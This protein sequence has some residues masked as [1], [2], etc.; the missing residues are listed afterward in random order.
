MTTTLILS[1]LLGA[2]TSYPL[3]KRWTGAEAERLKVIEDGWRTLL[4]PLM[5]VLLTLSFFLY[6][7][8][9]AMLIVIS[10]VVAAW[11][12]KLGVLILIGIFLVWSG[13]WTVPIFLL[14]VLALLS[15]FLVLLLF[16]PVIRAAI[17]AVFEELKELPEKVARKSL[18]LLH[19]VIF[20]SLWII[21]SEAVLVSANGGS[22]LSDSPDLCAW[23]GGGRAVPALLHAFGESDS[24]VSENAARHLSTM[25][26]T[27]VQSLL[28]KL[29][30]HPHEGVRRQAK[31]ILLIQGR[32]K[33]LFDAGKITMPELIG[34]LSH[35][36]WEVRSSV[37]KEL[38]RIGRPAL[39]DLLARLRARTVGLREDWLVIDTLKQIVTLEDVLR[40]LEVATAHE[41]D[42]PP[43]LTDLLSS[44]SPSAIPALIDGFK[45]P[46]PQVRNL[47]RQTLVKIG[48][49]AVIPLTEALKNK[50]PQIRSRAAI[51]L[52]DLGALLE[53]SEN[54]R[55]QAIVSVLV[56]SLNNPDAGLRYEVL[57][58]LRT[59]SWPRR[60][61]SFPVL[62][63]LLNDPDDQIVQVAASLI[64]ESADISLLP[65]FEKAHRKFHRRLN[66]PHDPPG[67]SPLCELIRE[68]KDR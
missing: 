28:M 59:T 42:L 39:P 24:G 22:V 20:V 61:S 57:E 43:G 54:I 51:T 19:A 15:P 49:P 64:V 58:T 65:A 17:K 50:D 10:A 41:N 47:A 7:L 55:N 11:S 2:A 6:P 53:D 30:E 13:L 9:H 46:Y 8:P 36:D 3:L 52:E 25:N 34:Y 67:S 29:E 37:M 1:T 40:L 38:V 60:K 18:S 44:L 5:A 27:A 16:A 26:N 66:I 63:A 45:H 21:A 23:V 35:Q 32:Y 14:L 48:D 12:R 4:F 68:L 33:H 31:A 56:K 62:F